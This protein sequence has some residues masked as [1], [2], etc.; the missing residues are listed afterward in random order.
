MK[1]F[2]PCLTLGFISC[3][4]LCS[5]CN[6]LEPV[7][8]KSV[9]HLLD[10]TV[11]ERSLTATAPVIAIAK[12]ALP[13]YLDRQQV[14]TRTGAGQ[15]GVSDYH[16]WA[17]PLDAAIA[18]VTAVNLSRLT[19]SLNILPAKDFVTMD[20]TSIIEIRISKFEAD[21]DGRMILECTWKVQPVR[22]QDV[23][24]RSFRTS[25]GIS[26]PDKDLSGRT[27]AMNEAL[28][29]LAREISKQL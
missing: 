17:E 3:C 18:R 16:L 19:R 13:S 21:G 26:Q 12:P 1:T 5:S 22:G 15:L 25:I 28:A 14:V 27:A 24:P 10:P 23:T 7:K 4:L 20:Y 29:Q 9:N 2:S 6:V 11:P 8:D